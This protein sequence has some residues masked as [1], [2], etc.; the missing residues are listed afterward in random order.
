MYVPEVLQLELKIQVFAL[1]KGH[2][3]SEITCPFWLWVLSPE[4]YGHF[5]LELWTKKSTSIQLKS[6]WII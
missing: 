6:N 4:D 2:P 1:R 5:L 3:A